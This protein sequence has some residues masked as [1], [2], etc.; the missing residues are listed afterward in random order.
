LRLALVAACAAG[1]A[2]ARAAVWVVGPEGQPMSMPAALE[3]ARDGDEIQVLPGKYTGPV[4]VV[5]QRRLTIRGIGKRPVFSGEG[6]PIE[7]GAL[8][9]VRD[10]QVRLENLEFTGARAPDGD[11]AGVRFERGRLEVRGCAFFDNE[12]GLV[13]GRARDAVLDIH[14]SEFGRAPRQRGGLN[15][16]L[17]VGPIARLAVQGSRFYGGFEG[18][19]LKSNARENFIAYNMIRDGADGEASYQIDLPSGGLASL[20]GNVIS[21][22]PRGQNPVLVSYGSEGRLWDANSIALTHNTLIS[23]GWRPGWFLRIHRD[24]IGAMGPVLAVNNLV[25]GSGIFELGVWGG[26]NR[27][28]GNRHATLGMLADV[29]TGAFELPPDS[30][31]RAS[32]DDPRTLVAP[33]LVPR[34]EF[35]WPAGLREIPADRARWVPGAYQR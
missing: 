25:V 7:G 12:Y 23:E 30:F 31:W 22:S 24:R 15:H 4:G 21:K 19:M 3:R 26:D 28:A 16:L 18:H 10:G 29:T 11:A 6:K 5:T 33:D 2:S 14:S 32:V 17:F 8:L 35:E 13:T 9:T 20:V 27:F 1:A 34:A